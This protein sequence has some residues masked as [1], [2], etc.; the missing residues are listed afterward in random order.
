MSSFSSIFLFVFPLISFSSSFVL[1]FPLLCSDCSSL[2]SAKVCAEPDGHLRGRVRSDLDCTLGGGGPHV[3]LRG[4]QLLKGE[5]L[6]RAQLYPDKRHELAK[7][8][9]HDVFG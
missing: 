2:S 8:S 9:V 3:D 4:V 6:L 5:P 7:K 1:F